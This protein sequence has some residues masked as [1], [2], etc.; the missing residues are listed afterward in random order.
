[1]AS[2]LNGTLIEF[3]HR[4]EHRMVMG[5]EDVFLELRM[6]SN[7]NLRDALCRHAVYICE[8]IKIVILRRNVNI[9]YIQK[10]SAVSLLHNLIQ[11]FP[12]GHFRNMKFGI[13]AHVLDSNGD[14]EKVPHFPNL[15]SRKARSF[16]GVGH[17][18]EVVRVTSIDAAPAEVVREPRRIC[19]LHQLLQPAEV[20]AVRLNS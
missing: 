2:A 10:N 19:A 4:I 12:F 3:P 9:I 17:G 13:T 18:K 7:V 5:I 15:L 11:E 1:M 6:A 14:F 16:K 20:L 8:W